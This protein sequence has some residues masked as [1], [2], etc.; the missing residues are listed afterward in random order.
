MGRKVTITPE[1]QTQICAM[2]GVG[3]SLR[4]AARLT[5]SRESTVRAS[6]RR[7]KAFRARYVQAMRARELTPLRN[8]QDA[9]TKH[10]RAAAWALE[11]L[12]PEEYAARRPDLF[13]ASEFT[14][15]VEGFAIMLAKKIRLKDDRTAVRNAIHRYVA[16]TKDILQEE[17]D[18]RDAGKRYRPDRRRRMLRLEDDSPDDER[19]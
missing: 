17:A 8:L 12:N 10:W 5:D 1:V 4:A 3:C 14:D 2:I 19:P 11:R 15:F 13:S 18:D 16:I 9:G 7:D 6:L